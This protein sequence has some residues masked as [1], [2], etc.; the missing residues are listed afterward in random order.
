MLHELSKEV[1]VNDNDG[2]QRFCDININISNRHAPRKRK[3]AQGNQ[4]PFIA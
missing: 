4:L 1:F 3:H 2:L